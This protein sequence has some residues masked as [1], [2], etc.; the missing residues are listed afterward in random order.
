MRGLRFTFGLFFFVLSVT[1]RRPPLGQFLVGTLNHE[2]CNVYSPKTFET[3]IHEHVT[4]TVFFLLCVK[5]IF[6]WFY[7][8]VR[9]EAK[10]RV[11]TCK[12]YV[13]C[14]EITI[15]LKIAVESVT[16]ELCDW[17]DYFASSLLV[18]KTD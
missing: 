11:R 15:V 16:L 17:R 10:Q 7:R 8:R 5:Y 13:I 14:R 9:F 4:H 2:N 3:L 6:F 12:D 1:R 18:K